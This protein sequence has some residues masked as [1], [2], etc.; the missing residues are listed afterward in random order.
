MYY[1][2]I[3]EKKKFLLQLFI[4]FYFLKING[5]FPK[6]KNENEKKIDK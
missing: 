3:A 5:I 6:K 1:R 4:I 2:I